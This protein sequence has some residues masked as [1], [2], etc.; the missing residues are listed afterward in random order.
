MVRREREEG[1]ERVAIKLQRGA[2]SCAHLTTLLRA[3]THVEEGYAKQ[4]GSSAALS[5]GSRRGKREGAMQRQEDGD[6]LT[7]TAGDP[8]K[9]GQTS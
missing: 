9:S 1:P 2:V 5:Q 3:E 7:R 6:E 8:L 4:T